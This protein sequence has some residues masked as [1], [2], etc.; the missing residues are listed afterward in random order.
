[1]GGEEMGE[2]LFGLLISVVV[3]IEIIWIDLFL[4]VMMW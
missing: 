2:G 3:R 4:C 1:M